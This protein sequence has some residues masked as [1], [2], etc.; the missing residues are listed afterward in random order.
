MVLLLICLI[1]SCNSNQVGNS[2]DVASI[3]SADVSA[4]ITQLDKLIKEAQDKTSTLSAVINEQTLEA[5]DSHNQIYQQNPTEVSPDIPSESIAITKTEAEP[6]SKS[7]ASGT[8]SFVIPTII[9]PPQIISVP[10]TITPTPTPAYTSVPSNM[11]GGGYSYADMHTGMV[12]E[13]ISLNQVGSNVNIDYKL[14][15]TTNNKIIK[16]GYFFLYLN[17]GSASAQKGLESN[18]I[19]GQEVSRTYQWA[20]SNQR[21]AIRIVYGGDHSEYSVVK[22]NLS[23][24]VIR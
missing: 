2:T 22:G 3:T 18:I 17:D 8:S 23:W 1:I 10:A 7:P 6:L 15:N 11:Q 20:I 14:R 5:L 16:E 9:Y 4:T 19:P 13:V 24:D 12:V 21:T